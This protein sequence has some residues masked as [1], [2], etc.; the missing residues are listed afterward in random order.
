MEALSA[1]DVHFSSQRQDWTTPQ[2]FFDTLDAEFGFTLDPCRLHETAKCNKYFTPEDDGL[3]QDWS[4]DVVFMNPPYGREIGKWVRKA[5]EES[6]RGA[7]VVC[8]IPARTDTA[9]WHDYVMK[10]EVRFVRGRLKF[11]GSSV[12]APFPSAVVIFRARKAVAA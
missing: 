7:T 8:L 6:Q 9:Y 2:D 12:G 1:M 11:G 5:Y 4:G 3:A 10:G